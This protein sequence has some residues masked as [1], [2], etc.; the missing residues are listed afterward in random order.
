MVHE[1]SPYGAD[2][3]DART[4]EVLW[5]TEAGDDTGRGFMAHFN[6]EVENAYWQASDNMSVIYD[7]DRNV[8]ASNVSHGGGASL[9][10]RIY[11][12]GTLADDF[13]DKSVLEYWNP[14]GNG[15][16]RMQVNGS[17]YTFGNLNN[18]SK[19]NPCVLGDLL[20]DWREEIV[21]WQQSGSD[22]QLVINATNYQTDYTFPHLMDD[23]A[24]RAQVVAQ[25]SVYNQ[26]P[27]VSYD[28]RTVKTIVPETFE[29]EPGSTKAYRYWGSFFTTYPVKIP[30][31]V[32]AWSISNR[33]E[34]NDVD[35][36]KVIALASGKI[37][38]GS[39]AVVFNSK[40]TTPRFVPT[41]LDSN[42]SVATAFAKGF[43]CDSLLTD[44]SE[45]KYIYEFRNGNR[46][47]GFYRT[48]GEKVIPG[49]KAYAV[50]GSSSQPGRDSYVMGSQFNSV[51]GVTDDIWT[52][53]DTSAVKN[54]VPAIYSIQGIRLSKEPTRGIYIKNGRKYVK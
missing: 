50:F 43:Y 53:E 5:R 40:T 29:V 27:H 37:I 13:Y 18:Y 34:N 3:R 33:E 11:W 1:H 54:D 38:P 45:G 7:T 32:K 49:G 12:N 22:Y 48:Y 47:P 4:G 16:W 51:A 10:N 2:L 52:I 46:G 30:E 44:T 31:D 23:Y 14:T 6:P 36:L 8:I 41:S 26:P 42:V 35:T 20:G 25:N 9:N 24:Y 39:R 15:F 19:Y 28:P 21:N 17:N